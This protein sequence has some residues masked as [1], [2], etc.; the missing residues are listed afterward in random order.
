MIDKATR[1]TRDGE[2]HDPGKV[3]AFSEQGD[4]KAQWASKGFGNQSLEQARDGQAPSGL[5]FRHSQVSFARVWGSLRRAGSGQVLG[6][7]A[8]LT[9][10]LYFPCDHFVFVPA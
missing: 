2:Q 8:A 9:Q 4:G 5:S 3:E 6:S 7:A 1:T 10:S